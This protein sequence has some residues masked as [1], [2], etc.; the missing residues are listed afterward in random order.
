MRIHGIHLQGIRA[1]Q[2]EQRIAFDPGYNAVV[3]S[4][5]DEAR[6]VLRLI[7]ALLYPSEAL[8]S[9]ADW[10]DPVLASNARAGLSFSLGS[11]AF[12]LIADFQQRRLVLGRYDPG[13]ERYERLSTEPSEIAKTLAGAGL[14][15]RADFERL[16]VCDLAPAGPGD[17]AEPHATAR[18]AARSAPAA[19]RPDPAAERRALGERVRSLRAARDQLAQLEAEE[20]EFGLD[21]SSGGALAD[22]LDDVD[23]PVERFREQ[24]GRR[25]QDIAGVEAERRILLDE[26]NRLAVVP[27][28]RSAGIWLG[29]ALGAVGAL[30]GF[31]VH[32]LFYTAGV[33]GVVAAVIG[34]AV[35]RGARRKL[36]TVEA[37][38]AGLRVREATIER[39]FESETAPLRSLLQALGLDSV[40]QLQGAGERYRELATRHDALRQRLEQARQAFP[41]EALAELRTLEE[42][43]DA[44]QATAGPRPEEV[45]QTIE[46]ER[47]VASPEAGEPHSPEELTRA[48]ERVLGPGGRELRMR[49]TSV[50]PI[51]LRALTDGAYTRAW[52]QPDTGWS[53]R[54]EGHGERVP[55]SEVS[56]AE[57]A[58]LVVAFRL[59]LLETLAPEVQHPLLV[60]PQPFSAIQLHDEVR[61]TLARAL[62]R[63]AR[64]VQVIQ[65]AAEESPWTDTATS[66]HRL[67][68]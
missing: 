6:A 23:E 37:R 54:R 4:D 47:E 28:S 17:G 16:L 30:A 61:T 22:Q 65:C 13:K 60:G 36:G 5:V 10:I 34:L 8:G 67:S 44:P 66:S 42:Q 33:A 15:A 59:A 55:W 11:A 58:K 39:R 3:A 52:Y 26:R 43:L 45:T 63:L 51:Y 57:R 31:L 1:P 29:V 64:V 62:H 9:F 32:E 27:E 49:L 14:P 2:G 53:L 25:A 41:T 68:T 24:S 12:R 56:A 19:R 48:A 38:L 18:P 46:F 21:A 50:L 7:D 35:N 20:K 40:E